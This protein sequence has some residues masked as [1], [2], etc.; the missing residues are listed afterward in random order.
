VRSFQGRKK[1][2]GTRHLV[3][4]HDHLA[5]SAALR[6]GWAIRAEWM[7]RISRR[8]GIFRPA[9][10]GN[11]AFV[12]QSNCLDS[13][14][15][16][17]TDRAHMGETAA[18]ADPRTNVDNHNLLPLGLIIVFG[19]FASTM[20][21]PQ[22]LGKL[23]LQFLLKNDV[24]ITREQM[25]AFFFWC[26]LAW[27]LKPFAGILTDALPFFGTRRRHYLLFSSALTALSWIGMGFLPHTY[28][29]LLLGAMIVNLFMVMAS[30]VT[31][32]YLVEAGQRMSATGRLTALRMVVYN[33]CTLIQGPLGGLLA[34]V[35]FIWA[36][37]ANA[38]LALTIFPI[39]YIYLKEQGAAQYRSSVV[40]QNAGQQLKTIIR[41]KN[42]WVALLF[43][44]LFYFSPGF[45][46]PLFYMQTDELHFSKQAIGNLGVFSGA[47]AILA[48][49]LYSQLIKRF[50]IRILLLIAVA[51]SACGTLLYLFYSN[52]IRAI[53]IESQ[54]GFLF[55]FAEITILDLAARATPKGCEGLGYSLMLS[56]RNVALF[57]ADVVGSYLADHKWPFAN[58][59]YLNAGTTA[60]VLILVPL[61]PATLMQSKD[62]ALKK[63]GSE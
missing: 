23:P 45:S 17:D 20:P 60:V 51:A 27:Y 50:H 54:N 32:A 35:G 31:G 62:A 34:T 36:T 61:L 16:Q 56:V 41:S 39:A 19:I 46:T 7:R 6:A 15:P 21:Q 5:L 29:S 12:R 47:F 11:Y 30:T 55:A 1:N 24:H 33:F 40:F 58:L 8:P 18:S 43:I 3:G 26:G 28:S 49:I 25:A 4:P 48:A 38:A 14:R 10:K 42:L 37:G 53:W 44:A 9:E 63:G 57:G 13:V 52:W 22:A 2:G 59:V